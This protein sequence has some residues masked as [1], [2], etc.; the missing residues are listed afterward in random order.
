MDLTKNI[1]TVRHVS[2]LS[3]SD[4][5]RGMEIMN[6][7]D[8][9]LGAGYMI[10]DGWALH[11]KGDRVAFNK[12]RAEGNAISIRAHIKRLNGF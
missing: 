12:A 6:T 9:C 5:R 11:V 1:V 7:N 10:A 2:G 3:V 4:I 8:P